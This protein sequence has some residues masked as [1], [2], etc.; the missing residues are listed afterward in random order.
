MMLKNLAK[1]EWDHP[2]ERQGTSDRWDRLKS[3]S[4]FRPISRYISER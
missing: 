1:F 4:D 3:A 2:K